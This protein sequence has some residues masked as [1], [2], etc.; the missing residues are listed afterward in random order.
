MIDHTVMPGYQ[1]KAMEVLQAEIT[2]LEAQ[3]AELRESQ[4]KKEWRQF[5]AAEQKKGAERAGRRYSRVQE[6]EN[7]ELDRLLTYPSPKV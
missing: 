3:Y 4:Q 5:L 2:A 6:A 1:T 7:R